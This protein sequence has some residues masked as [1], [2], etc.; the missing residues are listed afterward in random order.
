[1]LFDEL[2]QTSRRVAQTSGRRAKIELLAALLQRT[3]PEEIEPAIAMLSGAPRQGRIGIGYAT[4]E[5][6]RAEGGAAGGGAAPRG[7]LDLAEVDALLERLA[8]TTGKGSSQAKERLLQELFARA[9]PGEQEFLFR[10]L[11]GELRQGALE[12]L[13]TEAVA[14]GADLEPE[15]VRRAAML[16]GDLGAVAR[17]ARSEGAA[18]LARF[19][20]QLFRPIQPMLAQAADDVLD[21]LAQ[22][23]EAAFEYK[24]D[25]A[26]IQVHKAGDQVRVFS[27][28]LND[29]TVAVPEVVEAA[30]AFAAREAI[31]DGEAIALRPDGTPLPFQVTM[32]RFGRK[33][34]V[35]RLRAELPLA[36]FFFD[37]LYADGASLLDEPSAQRVAALARVV[38]A[39]ARVPRIVTTERLPESCRPR[40]ACRAS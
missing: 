36:S 33:L 7:S 3:G 13:M 35:D 1:M 19:Q 16:V 22:L 10:L 39:E 11:T 5:A 28:Q 6:A 9:T 20:V 14:R 38:P 15:A 25:G 4:L 30:R 12:G 17:A 2:V 37:L 27:R 18:G 23:G 31:L 34:D 29:V 8:R 32:R 24:L 21:A 40:L 26:R